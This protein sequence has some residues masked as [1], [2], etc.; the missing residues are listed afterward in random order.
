LFD[1]S[2]TN[3]SKGSD[4]V[5]EM[6]I[7]TVDAQEFTD[8]IPGFACSYAIA[9]ADPEGGSSEIVDEAV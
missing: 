4:Y 2:C 3:Q 6:F 5:S 8:E 1:N 9:A 7:S